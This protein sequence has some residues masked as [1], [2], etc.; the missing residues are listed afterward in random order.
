VPETLIR[1]IKSFKRTNPASCSEEQVLCGNSGKTTDLADPDHDGLT[2][3]LERAFN[4]NPK[5][6]ALPILVTATGTTG[7]PNIRSTGTDTSH[8]LIIEYLRRKATTNPGIFY[9]PQLTSDLSTPWQNFTGTET[10]ESIDTNWERVT[11]EDTA[12]GES[13]RF[14]RVKVS[15]SP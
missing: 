2:N 11:V 12:T 3:L 4:L 15:I 8:H 10:V 13:K 7:L 6:P 1:S 9:T 14:G 5:Q